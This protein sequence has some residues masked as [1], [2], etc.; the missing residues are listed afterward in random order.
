MLLQTLLTL[1]LLTFAYAT[2]QLEAGSANGGSNSNGTDNGNVL[3][4][5]SS[6]PTLTATS[7]K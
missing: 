6:S 4:V 1:T 7:S 3:P 2:P 5:G